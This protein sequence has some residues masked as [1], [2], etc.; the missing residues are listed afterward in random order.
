MQLVISE[1][2]VTCCID[3]ERAA[4]DDHIPDNNYPHRLNE[5]PS[6]AGSVHRFSVHALPLLRHLEPTFAV[7]SGTPDEPPKL[8]P[9][10]P[11]NWPPGE[12]HQICGRTPFAPPLTAAVAISP[13]DGSEPEPSTPELLFAYLASKCQTNGRI[14]VGMFRGNVRFGKRGCRTA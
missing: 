13:C 6:P 12:Y 8:K 14:G 2:G 11:E 5:A 7:P 3:Y 1:S 4:I 10:L 9:I